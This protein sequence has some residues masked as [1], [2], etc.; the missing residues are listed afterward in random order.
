MFVIMGLVALGTDA[1]GMSPRGWALAGVLICSGIV[2]EHLFRSRSRLRSQLSKLQSLERLLDRSDIFILT[3]NSAGQTLD[4]NEAAK[5]AFGEIVDSPLSAICPDKL[6]SG[7]ELT[8]TGPDKVNRTFILECGEQ[9]DEEDRHVGKYVIG[10]DITERKVIEEALQEKQA[11]I[12]SV[13]KNSPTFFF[14][15]DLKENR[16][17]YSNRSLPQ[18]LGYDGAAEAELGPDALGSLV[19]SEDFDLLFNRLAKCRKL[20]PGQVC[21]SEIRFGRQ[22]GSLCAMHVRDV[23]FK[24]DDEGLPWQIL[25]NMVDITK[26]R[27]LDEHVELQLLEIQDSNLALQIQTNALEEANCKLEELA[28]LD[29]LTGIANH[30]AFQERLAK[31]YAS[32]SAAEEP[33]SVVL[34]DV[35]Y[36]K[37]YNDTYGHPSGDIVLEKIACI[38]KLCCGADA[39]PA[40]YGGEEFAIICPGRT[41]EQTAELCE[42]IRAGVEGAPWPERRVT[43]SVGYTTMRPEVGL[44][45]LLVGQ[46]DRALYVAKAK[47][48][49]CIMSYFEA[50]EL[51]IAS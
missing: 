18:Y 15:F 42:R 31:E 43:V 4:A 8:Y 26:Q 34:L 37:L 5:R 32:A 38:L 9:Y 27:Q 39:I 14:T 24:H 46:A 28:N 17:L 29:G 12:E 44:A 20:S 41:L 33:L 13:A 23:L 45:S 1:A 7:R 2:I 22:D 51:R 25:I 10:F 30:R 40:R 35:D 21:E 36:F 3:A 49:N 6:E 47:G 11:F 16:L 19:Y 50:R 48:R